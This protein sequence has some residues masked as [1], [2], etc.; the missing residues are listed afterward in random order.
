MR[1]PC[2]L[3]VAGPAVADENCS[4]CSGLLSASAGAALSAADSNIIDASMATSRL[5][6]PS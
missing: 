3:K 6:V 4:G 5:A 1:L 2:R